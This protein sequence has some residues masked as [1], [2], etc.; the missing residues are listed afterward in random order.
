MPTVAA[1]PNASG[2]EAG[3]IAVRMVPSVPNRYEPPTPT[4]TPTNPPARLRMM[5]SIRNWIRT[6]AGARAQRL[7]QT[8]LARA[9]G[10]R[11]QHDVHDADAADEQRDARHP[12]Q[13]VTEGGGG[14]FLC[15]DDV[16]LGLHG[17]IGLGWVHVMAQAS[18]AVVC[19]MTLWI[20]FLAFGFEI[21][22]ADGVAGR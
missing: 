7:A 22:G 19:V 12:G 16:L 15:G 18:R 17:E 8:D 20:C 11:D 13:Q 2:M 3:T 21:D 6:S 5:A 9:F 4:A 14:G 10:D 1:A